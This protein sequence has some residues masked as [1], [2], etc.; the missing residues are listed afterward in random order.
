MASKAAAEMTFNF[1]FMKGSSVVQLQHVRVRRRTR[2]G[3][4]SPSPVRRHRGGTVLYL[5]EAVTHGSCQADLALTD[6][7]L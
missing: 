3:M 6:W 5:Q 4:R 7:N 1:D 2:H